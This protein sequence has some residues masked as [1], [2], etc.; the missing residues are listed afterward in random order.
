[1]A[2]VQKAMIASERA[3]TDK[4]PHCAASGASRKS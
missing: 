3:R 2:T 4:L 1:V